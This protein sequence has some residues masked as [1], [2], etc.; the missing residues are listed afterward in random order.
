MKFIFEVLQS[1]WQ[2]KTVSLV[3]KTCQR[4]EADRLLW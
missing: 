1:I 4:E 3:N 2:I